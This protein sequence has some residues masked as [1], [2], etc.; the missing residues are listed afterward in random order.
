MKTEMKKLNRIKYAYSDEE[1]QQL[2]K[3]GYV[4]ASGEK[5]DGRNGAQEQNPVEE[6]AD[7]MPHPEAQESEEK[8]AAEKRGTKKK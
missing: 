2:L 3:D 6:N 5:P 7:S 8:E 1:K 4:E